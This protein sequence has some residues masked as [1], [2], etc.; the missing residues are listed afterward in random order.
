MQQVRV[1]GRPW[2]CARPFDVHHWALGSNVCC[3]IS[4]YLT[5]RTCCVVN[6][7]SDFALFSWNGRDAALT[8]LARSSSPARPIDKSVPSEIENVA[9]IPTPS[10][11]RSDQI[12][13]LFRGDI[14]S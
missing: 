3:T 12:L 6:Q 13:L 5:K 10:C 14:F 4:S 1:I 9:D 8:H 7:S 2:P 11:W